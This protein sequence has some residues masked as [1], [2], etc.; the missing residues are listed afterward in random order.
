M[1]ILSVL[2]SRFQKYP[3]RHAGVNW[4]EVE[5][6]LMAD[7]TKRS[8]LEWMEQSGGEPDMFVYPSEGTEWLFIDSSAESPAGRCSLCYD[9]RA[10]ESRK[11]N[12]PTGNAEALAQT[13]RCT[14]LNEEQYHFLQ[15]FGP[16][17]RKT[18]SWLNTPQAVRELGGALFGD[19]RYGR[20]FIYHNGA[21]SYY[22]ARGFRAYLKI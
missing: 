7:A 8:A 22:A 17:D 20:T 1:D 14:L 10:W 12:K 15:Q 13:W 2:K 19:Y 5:A 9:Q 21:E 18:S 16:F 6:R 3:L 11:E 4:S